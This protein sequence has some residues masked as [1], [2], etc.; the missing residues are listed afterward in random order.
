MSLFC[1]KP[2]CNLTLSNQ[3]TLP[4]GFC[5]VV[6]PGPGS[7]CTCAFW[8][9]FP[10]MSLRLLSA[11]ADQVMLM[12]GQIEPQPGISPTKSPEVVPPWPTE[13]RS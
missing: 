1:D 6:I 12:C 4:I 10:L 7:L 2:L 9:P 13:D 8:M 11:K 3:V 5:H